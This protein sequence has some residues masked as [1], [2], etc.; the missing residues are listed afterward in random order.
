MASMLRQAG[1]GG[2]EKSLQSASALVAPD[3][4]LHV[5]DGCLPVKIILNGRKILNFV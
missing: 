4:R 2:L 3:Q 5:L 1:P